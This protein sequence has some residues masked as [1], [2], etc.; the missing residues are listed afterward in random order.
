NGC[1]MHQE[2]LTRI[3]DPFFTTKFTGR[4]LGLAAALGIIHSHKGV[5]KVE[6]TP[7][8]GTAFRVLCPALAGRTPERASVET[9]ADLAGAGA[10][11]VVDDEE[12]VR[13]FA[14]HSLEHYGY[15]VTLASSGDEALALF[16]KDPDA[17]SLVLLDMTMPGL[18]GEETFRQL[19]GIRPGVKVVLSTGHSETEASQHF[20]GTGIDAL[21]SKPYTSSRLAERIKSV[22]ADDAGKV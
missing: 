19:R 20:A 11:L 12:M 13:K 14:K 10:I 15:R 4:G 21:L 16:R 9:K 5:L 3:F 2:T 18:S 8:V 7:G 6:S 22:L 1:G 17:I